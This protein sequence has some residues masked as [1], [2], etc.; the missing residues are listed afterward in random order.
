[1]ASPDT[2]ALIGTAEA[3]GLQSILVGGNAVNLYGYHRTTFD[4]DLLVREDVATKWVSF[5]ERHGYEIL[6]QTHN[7]IRLRLANDP[8]GALPV[9]LMLAD[10]QTFNNILGESTRRQIA[11]G[12]RLAIASPLHLVAMKLHALR[13]PKRLE[14]GLDFQD[15]IYLIKSAKIDIHGKDFNEIAERYA[16]AETRAKIVRELKNESSVR[17]PQDG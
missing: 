1:M 16:T 3:E 14:Q 13:N 7:F 10:Q 15:V 12:I 4:V 9:D 8:A 17:G 11:G 5:F 2:I 6:Q